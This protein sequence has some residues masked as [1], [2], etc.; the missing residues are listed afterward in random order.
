MPKPLQWFRLYTEAVDD[1]K[2]RLLAFEDRWHFV[3]ILC[4]KGQGL[5]DGEDADLRMRKVCVKLGLDERELGEVARRLSAVGLIDRQTYHPLAWNHRQFRSDHDPTASSRQRKHRQN[6]KLNTV[7][8]ASRV[9]SRN[10]HG[11]VT[12]PETETEQNRDRAEQSKGQKKTSSP[13]APSDVSPQVWQDWQ[14]LRKA[15]RAAVT[16]TAVAGI[17]KEA[18]SIGMSLED[19]LSMCCER[20]W[21]G[22]KA[23]WVSKQ[24]AAAD[25][26]AAQAARVIK[27]LD[28]DVFDAKQ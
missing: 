15:K 17:R 1:E 5:L 6:K 24:A 16:A 14:A 2:L 27:L 3:A 18:S 23:E 25:K 22:F 20:G 28:G 13:S 26:Y 10:S 21:A 19:A 12:P 11:R 9:T 8:D 4:C 7:T